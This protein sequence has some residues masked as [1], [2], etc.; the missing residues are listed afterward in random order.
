MGE[1]FKGMVEVQNAANKS[2]IKLDGEKGTICA[3]DNDADGSFFLKSKD[4]KNWLSVDWSVI[5]IGG[6]EKQPIVVFNDRWGNP[7]HLIDVDRVILGNKSWPGR[8]GLTNSDG[9]VTINLYGENATGAL[10]D[11]GLFEAGGNGEKGYIILKKPDG[12]SVMEIKGNQIYAGGK[13][14]P[15][16]VILRNNAGEEVGILSGIAITLLGG[17]DNNEVTMS[18]SKDGKIEAG[19]NG[20][21]GE[22]VLRNANGPANARIDG[23]GNIHIGGLGTCGNIRLRN[24]SEQEYA[25]ITGEGKISMGGAGSP[26]E[27]RILGEYGHDIIKMD[28]KGDISVGGPFFYGSIRILDGFG[29]EGIYLAP[30]TIHSGGEGLVGSIMIRDENAKDRISLSAMKGGWGGIKLFE[31]D[32]SPGTKLD[33][34][35]ISTRD[36]SARSF[37]ANT[38]AVLR[39]D[40]GF[41][42]DITVDEITVGGYNHGGKVRLVDKAGNDRVVLDANI[43]DITLFGGDCAEEF[44]VSEN[45]EIDPGTVMTI[46]DDGCLCP[47]KK[48]FDKRVVGVVSGAKGLMPGLILREIPT[49]YKK[50]PIALMGTVHCKVDARH[51]PIEIGDLLTTS[52]TTGHAMKASDPLKSF[53]SVLGKALSSLREGTGLISILVNLQ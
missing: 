37:V 35:N 39:R 31:D 2:T 10:I 38:I 43:G 1:K 47:S 52:S 25:V 34:G 14:A 3:G 15:G 6:G 46:G 9:E 22:I 21:R 33:G 12:Q 53:G 5:T 7:V 51:S 27:I 11:S 49:K 44:E 8:L 42:G 20:V 18:V 23:D 32:G 19:G 48:P 16:L 29:K 41:G 30:G 13:G 40:D 36:I 45:E 24:P 28:G 17:I 50:L 26:G 4:G